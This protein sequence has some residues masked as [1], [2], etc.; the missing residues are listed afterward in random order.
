M[1]FYKHEKSLN[2]FNFHKFLSL[3]PLFLVLFEQH[4]IKSSTVRLYLRQRK[5][6]EEKYEVSNEVKWIIKLSSFYFILIG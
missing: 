2:N 4:F 1:L 5:E 6:K 3:I